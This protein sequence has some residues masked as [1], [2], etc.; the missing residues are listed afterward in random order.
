MFFFSRVNSFL[1]VLNN[2]TMMITIKNSK[3]QGKGGSTM[4]FGF[5]ARYT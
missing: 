1:R 3:K 2:E 5:S 4:A